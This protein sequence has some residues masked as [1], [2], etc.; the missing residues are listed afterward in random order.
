MKKYIVFTLCLYLMLTPFCVNA[1]VSAPQVSAQACVL[2]CPQNSQVIYSKNMDSP[3]GVA[4]TTKIMTTLLTLEESQHSDSV[5]EFTSVMC[6]EGS[7]MYLKVG[8]KVRL[9]DL[10]A[11]MMTVSGNDAA[12][13]AAVA[14]GGSK[15]KFADL[16]N[17]R[18]EEIGMKNT[19][20][21]N[22]SGLSDDNHY[23][24]AY[25]MALL[26]AEATENESFRNLTAQKS[27]TVDFVHPCDQRVTYYNHN[28]LL[29]SYDGCTGGKTGY[30]KATGRCLVTSA[31]RE[32]L[33]LIAV[34]LNAPDDWQDHK[35][36][37]EYGFSLYKTIGYEY[38]GYE[39]EAL[40]AGGDKTSVKA[41]V[42]DDSVSVL[43]TAD[44]ENSRCNIYMQDIAFAP[45]KTGDVLGKIVWT[46]KGETVLTKDI[47]SSEDSDE[48]RINPFLRILYRIFR[49]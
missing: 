41:V 19:H 30:T 39:F 5:V 42:S 8:D 34:T 14:I 18:A 3:M 29:T 49:R 44:A 36:M 37:Y 2:Y 40:V 31:M 9:S 27:V 22:P 21:V 7:S 10:A 25:D 48:V 35:T 38:D 33:E 45:V 6:A 16:M 20:F 1:Q 11:G 15:E 47:I 12:N 13:A 4:S 26:M 24:T 46:V 43:T 23:S 32:G 28:K 17:K